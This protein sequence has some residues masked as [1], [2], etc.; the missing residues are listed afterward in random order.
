MSLSRRKR[1]LVLDIS[2]KTAENL[3]TLCGFIIVNFA[4]LISSSEVYHV[5][6]LWIFLSLEL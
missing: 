4:C 6:L 1:D 2:Q 5:Y 3:E